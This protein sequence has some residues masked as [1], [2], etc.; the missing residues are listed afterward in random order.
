M[1]WLGEKRKTEFS[2]TQANQAMRKSRIFERIQPFLWYYKLTS[3]LLSAHKKGNQSTKQECSQ[4]S[5]KYAPNEFIC[6]A[7]EIEEHTLLFEYTYCVM[8][9]VY[10]GITRY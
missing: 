3:A 5:R 7:K 8:G 4:L 10:S 9:K 1:A 6:N 2:W